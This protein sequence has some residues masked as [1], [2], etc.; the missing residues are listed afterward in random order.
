MIRLRRMGID[1]KEFDFDQ[2]KELR[3][4]LDSGVDVTLYAKKEFLAIQMR[5]IRQ[6][7]EEGLDVSRSASPSSSPGRISRIWMARNS[8]LA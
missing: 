7:L 2:L 6:G 1:D 4:G 8:F 3:A 5:E